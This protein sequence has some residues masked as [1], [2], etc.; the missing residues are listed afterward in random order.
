MVTIWQRLSLSALSN[1]ACFSL[2][3]NDHLKY[4]QRPHHTLELSACLLSMKTGKSV[5][6]NYNREQV[7]QYGRARHQFTHTMTTG[8]KEDGTIMA[9]KHLCYKETGQITVDR[10]TDAHDCG[11][12][13]NV[14]SVE[15]QMEGSVSM[16]LGE[17]LFEEVK[18]DNKGHV[19]NADLAEYK[20]P[21]MLDM[22][23]IKTI[24]VESNEPNGP[25]GA[26]EVGEGAIMPTIPA[27][28]NAVY[29][30]IG[31]RIH[32]LPMIPE[33]AYL[34]IQ[35]AKKGKTG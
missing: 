17:A 15:G 31:V 23:Q 9:L 4:L 27:I 22:P 10:I 16:G 26:K 19:I 28:L 24:I 11:L 33:R 6:M 7:F 12:A 5:K 14:T 1:L 3:W 8:V 30:A 34:A 29:D 18:F 32:E 25:F 35:E 2:N 21:T 13:I 20:I